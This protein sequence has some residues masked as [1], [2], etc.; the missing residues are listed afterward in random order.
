MSEKLPI[1]QNKKSNPYK[2][3]F[4]DSLN[5]NSDWLIAQEIFRASGG[6]WVRAED[7]RGNNRYF[8]HHE[9]YLLYT[10]FNKFKS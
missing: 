8:S 1:E 7:K 10:K 4:G 5:L 2:I 3:K 6:N 9:W